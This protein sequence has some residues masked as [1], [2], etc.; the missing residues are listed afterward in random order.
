MRYAAP[1]K[2][3]MLLTRPVRLLIVLVLTLGFTVSI[4]RSAAAQGLSPYEQQVLD[5][6]NQQRAARGLPALRVDSRLVTA[7]RRH[8]DLMAQK[9]QLSHQLSG[10]RP[11]CSGGPNDDRYDEVGYAWIACG[12]NVAAGQTTPQEVVDAWMNSAGHRD[13][14]LNSSFRDIGIAHT[15]GGSYGHWWTQD[16]GAS[17]NSAPPPAAPAPALTWQAEYNVSASPTT[18]LAGLWVN[19][20]VT[21]RNTGTATWPAHGDRRVRLGAHFVPNGGS[22]LT[23]TRVDLPYNLIPGGSVS[24]SVWQ[25]APVTT[26]PTSLVFQLVKEGD[27][28]F[29]QTA[30]RPA[31]IWAAEYNLS[32]TPSQWWRGKSQ[33]FTVTIRNAGNTTWSAGG[34]QMVRLGTHFTS[35]TG[36]AAQTARWLSDYRTTLPYDIPPGAVFTRTIAP[37]P[38]N[39]RGTMYLETTMVREGSFWFNQSANRQVNVN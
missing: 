6:V 7:A 18:W 36:G 25:A 13:N 5:L 24:L 31:A 34:S 30:S 33:T 3:A 35:A 4:H 26:Q 15:T 12:E 20:A 21:V 8:N 37:M 17:D 29:S 32:Q 1:R 9:S 10:E 23:D 19:Y 28:W 22:W 16:F 14:I 27:F 39:V 2:C 38:P 11:L